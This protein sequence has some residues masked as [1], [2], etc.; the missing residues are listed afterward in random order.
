[1]T[2]GDTKMS[3]FP[4][5]PSFNFTQ[6]AAELFGNLNDHKLSK[7][8]NIHIVG[9]LMTGGEERHLWAVQGWFPLLQKISWHSPMLGQLL[10]SFLSVTAVDKY[11]CS[12]PVGVY[13]LFGCLFKLRGQQLRVPGAERFSFLMVL[14]P[15]P[16]FVNEC[17]CIW[18]N[19][20]ISRTNENQK[21]SEGK[22][23]LFERKCTLTES[24]KGSS[25]R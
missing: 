12:C 21:M 10:L 9:T 24:F 20:E 23:N 18:F 25:I 11:F 14:I 1:M 8:E 13:G 7:G 17:A 16:R 19:S 6:F 2:H 22:P 4:L 5:K 15:W 3:H